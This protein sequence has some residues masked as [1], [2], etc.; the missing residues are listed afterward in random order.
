MYV[1][2]IFMN[3]LRN[4]TSRS[5]LTKNASGMVKK[6]YWVVIVRKQKANSAFFPFSDFPFLWILSSGS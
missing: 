3:V 2:N 4:R 5:S 1:I 6:K